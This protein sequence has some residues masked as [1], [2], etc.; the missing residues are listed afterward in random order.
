MQSFVKLQ[1]LVN[2][3]EPPL[4]GSSIVTASG[5]PKGEA[6]KLDDNDKEQEEDTSVI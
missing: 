2:L 6:M 5:H 4:G 3:D 1:E